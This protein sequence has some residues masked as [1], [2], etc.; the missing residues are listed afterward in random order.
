LKCGGFGG[1]Q[2]EMKWQKWAAEVE[3]G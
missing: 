2:V 3:A 1:R